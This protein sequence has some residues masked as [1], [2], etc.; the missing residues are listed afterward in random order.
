[1]A[2]IKLKRSAVEGKVPSTLDLEL[3]ELGLNTRDGKAYMKKNVDGVESIIEIGSGEASNPMLLTTPKVITD[4]V[5]VGAADH[6]LSIHAVEVQDGKTVEV[7]EGSV[8][9]VVN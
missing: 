6:A 1:M 3:G 9:V 2:N 8:W 4:D 5:V 7:S